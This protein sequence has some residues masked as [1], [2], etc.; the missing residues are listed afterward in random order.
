M[1]P[2][3]YKQ[4]GVDYGKIDPL[5]ILAQQAAAATAGNLQRHGLREVAASRGESA[6]LVDCGDFYLASITECLGTKALVADATRKVTGKTYYDQIAQ[7]TLAMAINDLITVGASPVSVHAYWAAGGSAWFD[8][9]QRAK[10]LVD[11]WRA[12][13]DACGVAWGGGETPALAGVVADDRIDLA[14]SCVGLVRPKARLTLGERLG[15]GDAIVLLG[16]S[17]IHANGVSLARKLAERLPAGYATKLPS[18][19]L[20]GEAL[21]AP[22]VLYSPV[23]EALAKAG[24]VPHYQAN[25]TGHGWRKVMRHGKELTYRFHTLP[26]VP[27]V[28]QFLQ[29]QTGSDDRAAYGNLNMGAGYALFVAAGDAARTVQ[30]ARDAGVQAW[31]AGT[32]EAGPKQVVLEPLR[33]VFGGDD[34]HVRA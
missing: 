17:G 14:A 20:F 30:I 21:L 34:L 26:P 15:P 4:A 2:I 13:C 5:K 32:V 33:L 27:E 31:A 11:G 24:I 19:A 28:L 7:D 12:A 22:T 18:G 6:Y 1:A 25:I 8:D 23:T 3:D 29:Q 10:D 16:S 9:A